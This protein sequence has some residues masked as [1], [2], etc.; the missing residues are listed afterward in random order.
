MTSVVTASGTGQ[1]L[2]QQLA[3]GLLWLGSCIE[4]PYLG[5][6]LHTYTSAF[7]VSGTER[8]LLVD[9]GLTCDPTVLERQLS[10]A[11][12]DRPP[13]E[14]IFL[15]HQET[16]HAGAAGRILHQYPEA[17]AIGDVRDYH[18]L[19]PDYAE[20]FRAVQTGESV[21]LGGNEFVVLEAI[22][23]DLPTT[24][25]GFASQHRALFSADGF[26]Y[27]HHHRAGQCGQTANELPELD[28]S[29]LAHIFYHFALP[30]IQ[31]TDM[32]PYIQRIETL[33]RDLD[34]QLLA[35]A[36]GPPVTEVGVA[37]PELFAALR[38]A[39]AQPL[40]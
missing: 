10:A 18:L 40:A 25:W 38:N 39:Q 3:P 23:T 32:D 7:L 17:I 12:E 15:S 26:A 19:F 6:I 9:P 8:S 34:V 36:H 1:G 16:P 35:P 27:A 31:L 33:L 24:R 30:W 21:D 13:L 20:R 11:L 37:L 2:P 22:I 4:N 28:I 5:S 29:E 14:Y